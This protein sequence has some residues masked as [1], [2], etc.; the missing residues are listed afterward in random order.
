M[1]QVQG[2][3]FIGGAVF[4]VR[5]MSSR[6][7]DFVSGGAGDIVSQSMGRDCVLLYRKTKS[8]PLRAGTKSL[9][10]EIL[11]L[12]GQDEIHAVRGLSKE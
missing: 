1:L 8:P 12:E 11:P 2:K 9:R 10:D 3:L 4:R 6:R 7:E 5:G